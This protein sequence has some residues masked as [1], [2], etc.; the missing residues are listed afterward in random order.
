MMARGAG[1]MARSRVARQ[2]AAPAT[3]AGPLGFA[4]SILNPRM[5]R[6]LGLTEAQRT[7]IRALLQSYR[8]EARTLAEKGQPIRKQLDDAVLSNNPA[9]IDALAPELGTLQ[10]ENAKL[11]AKI[12]AEV[13]ALLTPEQQEKAKTLQQRIERRAPR[14]PRARVPR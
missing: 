7:E 3:A 1:M 5:I 10:A 12:H 6:Q 11:R 8:D 14:Q 13:F 2:A 4:R 9:A